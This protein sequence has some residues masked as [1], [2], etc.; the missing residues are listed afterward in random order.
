MSTTN[1]TAKINLNYK[2]EKV[3]TKLL[4]FENSR[5]E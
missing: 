5:K 4:H 3:K 1:K 2:C